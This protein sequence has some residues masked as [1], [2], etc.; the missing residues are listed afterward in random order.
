M[1]YHLDLQS[2]WKAGLQR[3]GPK[4]LRTPSE[5]HMEDAYGKRGGLVLIMKLDI[6][7]AC[8]K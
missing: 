7:K 6:E 8:N 4:V 2:C 1:K 5:I 3:V